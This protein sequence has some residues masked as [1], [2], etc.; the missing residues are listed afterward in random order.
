MCADGQQ[1]G[2]RPGPVPTRSRQPDRGEECAD[3]VLACDAASDQLLSKGDEHAPL[4]GGGVRHHDG[5]QL[6]DGLQLGQSQGVVAIGLAFEVLELPGLGRSV[7][8]LHAVA[9]DARQVV[10][11]PGVG[12]SLDND[13]R[14]G[15]ASEDSRECVG[16]SIECAEGM[17]S[18]DSLVN[19]GDAVVPTQVD[20]D[21][22]VCHRKPPVN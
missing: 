8:D 6:S 14:A 9:V 1:S 2:F 7:G 19:A 21:N 22:R 15:V 18:C 20:G 3:A 17:L 10:N 12:T 13:E 11:P 5:G 4:P 16:R